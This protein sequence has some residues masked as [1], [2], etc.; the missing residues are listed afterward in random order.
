MSVGCSVFV[1]AQVAC[2]V[3]MVPAGGPAEVKL[4]AGSS[5]EYGVRVTDAAGATAECR[6]PCTLKVT[7]G[8]ADVDVTGAAQFKTKVVIP[9]GSSDGSVKRKN[10]A[11][12]GLGYASLGGSIAVLLGLALLRPPPQTTIAL[13][14]GG[15][16]LAVASIPLM[17]LAGNNGVDVDPSSAPP[18]APAPPASTAPAPVSQGERRLSLGFTF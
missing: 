16:V 17:L 4:T 14:G 9:A 3:P 11:L 1:L 12:A 13:A 15:L 7:S 2:G 6:T 18:P 5:G 10:S 8:T